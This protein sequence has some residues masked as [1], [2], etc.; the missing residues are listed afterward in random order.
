MR[1][2]DHNFARYNG[3]ISCG[4][5]TQ[6]WYSKIFHAVSMQ[7]IFEFLRCVTDFVDTNPLTVW[8][9]DYQC[10]NS[11]GPL[12]RAPGPASSVSV[13]VFTLE[14]RAIYSSISFCSL[15]AL[16][17][18]KSEISCP[19]FQNSFLPVYV[20]RDTLTSSDLEEK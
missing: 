12:S 16:H 13:C 7:K 19:S 1:D 8:L 15:S 5:A 2:A 20:F 4:T 18:L 9:M 6:G 14:Y 17:K 11:L 3:L 10:R